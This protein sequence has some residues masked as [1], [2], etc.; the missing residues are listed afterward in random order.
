MKVIGRDQLR[1]YDRSHFVR[2][3]PGVDRMWQ[4]S[5]W[6][7]WWDKDSGVGGV[8]RIGHEYNIEGGPKVALWSNLV[9]PKGVYKH[10]VY[11]PL[12]ESDKLPG[13]WGGGDDTCRSVFEDDLHKW[14]IDDPEVGVSA[15]LAFS[16]FHDSFMGFPVSGRTSEDIAPHHIDVGGSVN[17]SITM[18]GETFQANGMG[19]RDHGWGHRDLG[20]MLSHRY[21][22][23]TFGPDLTFCA[24]SIHNGVNNSIEAFGWVV[25]DGVVIFARDIDIV[26]YVEVDSAST[27][28]GHIT[29]T[30]AND[31]TLDCELTA[32]AP[33]LMNSF[34]IAN[35]NTLCLAKCRGREGAGMFESMMNYHYGKRLPDRMQHGLVAN[36]FHPAPYGGTRGESDG[37]LLR[38]TIL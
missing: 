3:Q 34:H 8:H 9:T 29:M 36:G 37:P 13:G 14:I 17:G 35:M 32:V 4:D 7:H 30:L 16:D 25:Q 26:T 11:Q 24:W 5:T 21:V 23:G 6:L 1:M 33:G 18:A 38:K 31:D 12:R 28:G 22:A 2:Q 19:V 27:R 15:Q 20:T 10:V